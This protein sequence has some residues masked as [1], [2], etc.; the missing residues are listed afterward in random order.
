MNKSDPNRKKSPKSYISGSD[1]PLLNVLQN[2]RYSSMLEEEVAS[3]IYFAELSRLHLKEYYNVEWHHYHL[4][5]VGCGQ[6]LRK[7]LIFGVS[8]SVTGIDLELPFKYPYFLDFIK[9]IGSSGLH[10]AIKTLA[11]QTLGVDKRFQKALADRLKI[12]KLPRVDTHYMNAKN[13]QFDDESFDGVFSFSVFQSI[14]EPSVAVNEVHRVLKRGRI[15]YIQLHLYTAPN[16]SDCP[17]AVLNPDKYPP[18]AHLRPSTRYYRKEGLYHNCWRLAQWKET[19]EG[20]FDT[21]HYPMIDDELERN[22]SY[23][24]PAIREELADYSE[25]ELLITT[26]TAVCKKSGKR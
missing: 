11:R 7:A 26:L 16:G 1:S 24:S 20:V 2:L 22:R 6:L 15:A 19:F 18:W 3:Q 8:N 13:L 21:V 12:S 9:C 5:D 17:V 4:L 23:L 14:D 10:R 25:E